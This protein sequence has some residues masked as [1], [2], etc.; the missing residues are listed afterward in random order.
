MNCM[1]HRKEGLNSLTMIIKRSEGLAKLTLILE[2]SGI[3]M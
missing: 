3:F 1:V 2:L